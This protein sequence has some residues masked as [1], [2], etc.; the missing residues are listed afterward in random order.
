[1]GR[2]SIAL[3]L[4]LIT[5]LYQKFLYSSGYS[6]YIK[7]NYASS[8]CSD[9]ETGIESLLM[10]QVNKCY[11]T[12]SV[13]S[14]MTMCHNVTDGGVTT[15]MKNTLEW[16]T[17]DC[18]GTPKVNFTSPVLSSC[19]GGSKFTCVIDPPEDDWPGLGVWNPDADD[20][21]GQDCA[22]VAG[23][24][25]VQAIPPYCNN[26]GISTSWLMEC[27]GATLNYNVYNSINCSAGTKITLLEELYELGSCFDFINNFEGGDG[28][29]YRAYASCTVA[30]I[31]G[32]GLLAIP[33]D[34][35]IGRVEDATIGIGA[36]CGIAFGVLFFVVGIC[37]YAYY[38]TLH[39]NFCA[40]SKGD[41]YSKDMEL[42]SK[43]KT[44]AVKEKEMM[45]EVD[46]WDEFKGN[47]SVS[48]FCLSA[49]SCE[50]CYEGYE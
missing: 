39:F 26:D 4:L 9:P 21:Q 30:T 37:L 46:A 13:S 16:T 19:K 38:L 12:S 5:S 50:C 31:P 28:I 40:R 25:N 8:D 33:G 22:T 18:G 17:D 14:T 44:K 43:N 6:W 32:T 20:G 49:F 24:Q 3:L 41:T 27:S 15:I 34:V 1:M 48:D 10:L 47:F 29:T 42:S 2:V 36:A 11:Q 45:S 35:T 7:T 23:P